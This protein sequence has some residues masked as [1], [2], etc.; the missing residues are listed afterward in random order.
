[1]GVPNYRKTASSLL[2]EQ[3][4]ELERAIRYAFVPT[5]NSW[6]E[7][8]DHILTDDEALALLQVLKFIIV[9]NHYFFPCASSLSGYDNQVYGV[10][11]LRG[12][13]EVRV[14]IRTTED[15]FKIGQE[16]TGRRCRHRRKADTTEIP[17][18]NEKQRVSLHLWAAETED[19]LPAFPDQP[20]PVDKVE[21]TE[22]FSADVQLS[23]K[24]DE[25]SSFK[26]STICSSPCSKECRV[27][28]AIKLE[29][30][31]SRLALQPHRRLH[32]FKPQLHHQLRQRNVRIRAKGRKLARE[33]WLTRNPIIQD[34]HVRSLP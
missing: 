24:L 3:R 12:V 27:N 13:Q 29:R 31:G 18:L 26:A 1:M 10:H 25:T 4:L 32:Q 9:G 34:V 30:R 28:G 22:P 21:S 33:T 14:A 23:S 17:M 6:T 7:L 5:I 2:Q 8:G 11:F 16:D 15:L 19:R 20:D